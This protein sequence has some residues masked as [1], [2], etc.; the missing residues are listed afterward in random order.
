MRVCEHSPGVKQF[1]FFT[2][3]LL[4]RQRDITDLFDDLLTFRAQDPVE[5]RFHIA[6]GLETGVHVQIAPDRIR[7]APGCFVV[8][9]SVSLDWIDQ[10]YETALKN[11]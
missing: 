2:I 3:L 10:L 1:R 9:R 4:Q 8:Q 6:L 7:P 11:I 5:I